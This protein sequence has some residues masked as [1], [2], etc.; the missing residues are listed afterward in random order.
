[1]TKIV[2]DAQKVSQEFQTNGWILTAAP[3][4]IDCGAEPSING[5]LIL[6]FTC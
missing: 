1:V 6:N 4:I 5:A 3:T 2:S